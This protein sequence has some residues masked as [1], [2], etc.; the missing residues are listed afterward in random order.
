MGRTSAPGGSRRSPRRQGSRPGHPQRARPLALD[1]PPLRVV[2]KA[3]PWLRAA[4]AED[5]VRTQGG[6]LG[7]G[8]WPHAKVAPRPSAENL[9]DYADLAHVASAGVVVG[10]LVAAPNVGK[11][12]SVSPCRWRHDLVNHR[13][14]RTHTCTPPTKTSMILGATQLRT[15]MYGRSSFTA[16]QCPDSQLPRLSPYPS[17]NPANAR[18]PTDTRSECR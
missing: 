15:R 13:S 16:V 3:Q 12:A 11:R 10:Y 8:R 2:G 7:I 18:I 14:P 4:P 5:D 17:T 9:I 1:S 6:V